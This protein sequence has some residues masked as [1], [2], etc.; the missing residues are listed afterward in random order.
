MQLIH[1]ASPSFQS[2]FMV[3]GW[4]NF[5]SPRF[6]AAYNPRADSRSFV[7]GWKFTIISHSALVSSVRAEI[8]DTLWYLFNFMQI[9]KVA[10]RPLAPA[11]LY[12]GGWS[13]LIC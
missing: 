6:R 13:W 9:N 7:Q 5:S 3:L 8:P 12:S 4:N 11:Q 1:R 10:Q 2:V